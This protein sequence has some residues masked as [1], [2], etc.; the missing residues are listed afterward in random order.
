MNF[1]SVR[2]GT[3]WRIAKTVIKE[4]WVPC[5][6]AIGLGMWGVSGEKFRNIQGYFFGFLMLAWFTGQLVRIKREIERKDSTKATIDRLTTLSE[7]LDSQFKLIAGHATGGDSHIIVYPLI[8]SVN[9]DVTVSISV[10]GDFPVRSVDITMQNLD[11]DFPWKTMKHDY[12]EVIWPRILRS[13]GV[14][15]ADGQDHYRCLV[16]L[17]A[18]NHTTTCEIVVNLNLNGEFV[19]ANR[20]RVN[21]KPW[22]YSIPVD[23]PESD[24]SRPELL[25]AFDMPDDAWR[26]SEEIV[27]GIANQ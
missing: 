22:R 2:T 23:F 6:L 27:A 19:V 16:Q 21:G 17:S 5:A 1:R 24:A 15:S 10:N 20:Q 11:A 4:F 9:G 14:W 25:F 8:N 13:Q 3:A 7:K 26:D 18:L 12:Q